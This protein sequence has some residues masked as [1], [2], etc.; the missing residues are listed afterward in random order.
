MKT[1]SMVMF[2]KNAEGVIRRVLR[3]EHLLLTYRGRPAVR[4]EPMT[5]RDVSADDPFYSIN[6]LA[7][8]RGKS[9][10]NAEMDEAIYG[11]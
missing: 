5:P 11:K 2:R 8:A 1:V 10:T 7:V 6:R 9:M 3:G 4:M